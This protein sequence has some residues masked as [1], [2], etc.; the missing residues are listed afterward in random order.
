MKLQLF[1]EERTEKATPKK[2]QDIKKKG[3]VF[4]SK[5]LTAAA[6]ILVSVLAINAMLPF[7]L[8][9]AENFI[10]DIFTIYVR[11]YEDLYTVVNLQ[12]FFVFILGTALKVITPLLI[13]IVATGLLITYGQVGFIF[14]GETLGFK[15]ERINPL[16]G[17][18]RIFSTKG[19]IE[20][21][22]ALLKILLIG[23]V[24]YST[25]RLQINMLP[26]L[27]DMSV[28]DIVNYLDSALVSIGLKAGMLILAIS[29]LDY[30]YQWWDFERS[31][32]MTKQEVKDEVREMEGNP[33]VKSKIREKQRR[34]ALRRMMNEIPKADVVVT[35]PT[36]YAVALK[37]DISIASA[38]VVVAKGV[39][40]L[41]QKI[42]E[43]AKKNRVPIVENRELAKSLYDMADVG[44]MIPEELYY[45]VAEVLA[46][47]YSIN[48][49]EKRVR[50]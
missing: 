6:V 10:K 26:Q 25:I 40:F 15:L 36:H 35:N 13:L 30:F 24:V 50:G 21:G 46:F 29:V 47:V 5:D 38:P 44:D 8:S 28:I 1:A 16:E 14:T 3:Q 37:Y 20:L 27:L 22:K 41:A 12:S 39:D 49:E 43:E 4:Q 32:K 34:I 2:R 23:Y 31:I 33:Q 11:D 42:K 9:T 18:K 45:A 19:I 17:F 48:R 7:I